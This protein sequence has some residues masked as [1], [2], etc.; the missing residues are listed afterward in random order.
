M[1][2]KKILW[3]C[4][5]YPSAV[6]PFNGDFIQR[7]AQAAALYNDI[8]VIYIVKDYS[9]KL[10]TIKKKIVKDGGLTEHIVIYSVKKN[11]WSRLFSRYKWLFLFRQAIRR[12]M[13]ENKKPDIVHVQVP[14]SA[15]LLAV[16]LLSKYKLPFF[17]TEHYGIYNEKI[18]NDSYIN[19]SSLFKRITKRIFEKAVRFITVSDY[20][21]KAVN[22]MVIKKDYHVIPNTVDT[23]L[24]FYKKKQEEAFRFIHVSNMIPLKNA[25]GILRAF[26][27]FLRKG[28][29]AELVMVGGENY[30]A[31]KTAHLLG[32]LPGTVRFTGEVSYANVAAEMQKADC[33]LL[34]SNIENSPCVIGEAL[35]CGLPVIASNVGGI[36]ELVNEG[37]GILVNAGDECNLTDAMVTITQ[38]DFD[39]QKIAE[40]AADKFSYEIIGKLHNQLYQ[41]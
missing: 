32:F 3:L 1:V 14:V 36:P 41:E 28:Y 31:Q 13:V 15:G 6:N 12:Y 39:R 10:Q 17:V 23:S 7:H 22:Q 19:R 16:W 26:D 9:G 37:N 21:G 20:L 27:S 4:S 40:K 24:F 8:Y 2:R 11:G 33:L 35:C 18:G 25:D 38:K 34:F 30:E 5:W 29:H